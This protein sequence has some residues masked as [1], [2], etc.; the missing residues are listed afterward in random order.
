MFYY[1]TNTGQ[2]FFQ[3]C[4]EVKKFVWFVYDD[5]FKTCM[6]F[7]QHLSCFVFVGS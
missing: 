2:R 7:L 4:T 6:R 1:Y 5:I 3:G